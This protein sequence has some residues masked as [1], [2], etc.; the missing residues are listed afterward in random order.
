MIGLQNVLSK[1]YNKKTSRRLRPLKSFIALTNVLIILL[2]LTLFNIVVI[3]VKNP[4]GQHP[5]SRLDQVSWLNKR[6]PSLDLRWEICPKGSRRFHIQLIFAKFD[7]LNI[8]WGECWCGPNF[9]EFRVNRHL[10]PRDV[11][12]CHVCGLYT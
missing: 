1:F 6:K 4:K 10:S 9:S 7:F 12:G 5:I 8:Y 2:T 3:V 11:F